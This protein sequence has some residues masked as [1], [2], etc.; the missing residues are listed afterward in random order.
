MPAAIPNRNS[1]S[2]RRAARP[3]LENLEPR[4][5]LS[6][7]AT[8]GA[9]AHV[10]IVGDTLT[11]EGTPGPDRIQILPTQFQGT[12]RVVFDGKMLGSFGS[13][14]KID[15]DAG[16]RNDTITVDPRITLPT[17]LEGGARNDRLRGGSGPN[18][19]L[20]GGGNDTLIGDKSRDTLDGGPGRNRLV[21]VK[22]LGVVQVG[23]SASGAGLRRLSGSYSLMPLQ[24]A[25]PAVVGAADLGNGRIASQLIRDFN[26]GQP[27]ALTNATQNTANALATMLGYKAPVSFPAG[28]SQAS[29]ITFRKINEGARTVFS[30]SILDPQAHVSV[31]P[32]KRVTGQR[33]AAQ[34]VRNFLQKAFSVTPAV[35]APPNLGGPMQDLLNIA[36]AY[37]STNLYTDDSG[38]QLQLTDTIYNV[39]S[40]TNSA[41][42]YYVN[43]EL[44]ATQGTNP[45][46][47][48]FT[49]NMVPDTTLTVP[50]SIIQPSPNSNPPAT[51]YTSGVS[52]TIGGSFGI[53]EGSGLNA[54]LNASITISNSTTQT[55]PP[56][57]IFNLVNPKSGVTEW[58]YAFS[59]PPQQGVSTALDDQWIWQVPF[60]SYLYSPNTI[61]FTFT[62]EALYAPQSDITDQKGGNWSYTAPRPFGNTL[63]LQY[64]QVGAVSQ[65]TVNPGQVFTIE[66][67]GL[68]PATIQGVLI[69]GQPLSNENFAPINAHEIQ[70]VAPNTPGNALLVVVLTSQGPSLDNV[71]I[72]IT[73][74]SLVHVQAQN[75]SAQTGQALFEQQVASFTYPDPTAP[76]TKFTATITE[77]SLANRTHSRSRSY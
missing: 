56:I 52:T 6:T 16:A 63:A 42:Y 44:L 4:L 64:P 46:T 77:S 20:G 32:S 12:V 26:G 28:V 7:S 57:Q 54:S 25:G 33:L 70:V 24:V 73:G 19:L 69:G 47:Y 50:P 15:V 48:L 35:A 75:I 31:A 72:N 5:V 30:T 38:A 13:V 22:T 10:A 29:L 36:N 43:Q 18:V 3:R 68:Y 74:P 67:S 14:A 60:S 1:R 23:P 41:D 45:F 37:T 51:T 65:Q 59:T 34:G 53:N 8:L 71:S 66:G 39:R 11:V 17:Q 62:S 55:I 9:A 21:A 58:E 40:F 2:P 76:P 49:Q 61:P 27:L